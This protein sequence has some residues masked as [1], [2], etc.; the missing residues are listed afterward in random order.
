MHL[1]TDSD[2]TFLEPDAETIEKVIRG[3]LQDAGGPFAPF[4]VLEGSEDG[5]M[6]IQTSANDATT[7]HVDYVVYLLKAGPYYK[8][9]KS[10]NVEQRFN[11]IRLQLPYPVEVHRIL[12]DDPIGIELYWHKRFSAKRTNGEWFLLTDEDVSTFKSRTRM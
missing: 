10:I 8:I 5:G 3:L 11:Q 2:E 12:T 9:G 1:R 4:A 7:F 6:F